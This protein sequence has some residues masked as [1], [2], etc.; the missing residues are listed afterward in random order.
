[1]GFKDSNITNL[2]VNL[3]INT[4]NPL[5]KEGLIISYKKVRGLSDIKYEIILPKKGDHDNGKSDHLQET[6]TTCISEGDV[7]FGK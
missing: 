5:V 1:M 7:G 2:I 4:L 6:D 3:E